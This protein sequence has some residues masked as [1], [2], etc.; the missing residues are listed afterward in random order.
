MI[1]RFPTT[2]YNPGGGF[3]ENGRTLVPLRFVGENL[4]ADIQWEGAE[5]RVTYTKGSKVVVLWVGRREALVNGETV[6]LDV[7]PVIVNERTVVPLRFVANAL[8][9]KVDWDGVK[10]EITIRP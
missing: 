9:A 6:V 5:R 4:G 8:E 2:R 1:P 10:Y 3:I 7:P